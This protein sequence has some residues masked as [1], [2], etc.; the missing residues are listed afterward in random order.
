[1]TRILRPYQIDTIDKLRAQLRKGIKRIVVS[2]CCG[3]GKTTVA[4]EIIDCALEKGKS[5]IFIVDRI[6]LINQ[7]SERLD[8]ENIRHGIIQGNH[9]RSDPNAL[10]QVAS[11]QTL[12]MRRVPH[13]DLGIIDECH[14]LHKT[15]KT[16]MERYYNVT[17]IGL[18]A[19]PFTKGLGK[20]FE[21]L[22]TGA[23]INELISLKYLIEPTV[24]APSEPDMSGV[25]TVAGDYE[26][27]GASC[28]VN[29]PHLVADIVSTWL[30][31][32]KGLPTLV[33]AQDIAHSKAICSDFKDSG[34]NAVHIDCY[35]KTEEKAEIIKQHKSGKI[36]VLVNVGILDKGY[37]YPGLKCGVLARP[38]RSLIL[39]IQQL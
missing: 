6:S 36:T 39:H 30:K 25:K 37:D 23:T 38:T 7:V 33:F 21:S 15:H 20:H 22:V 1:M 16:I 35:L 5:S 14:V 28:A 27:K 17:F 9:P 31:L 32:A 18:S 34:V 26:K 19:T 29:K 12:A 24:Y 10:V 8:E 2:A 4:S 13:F 3:Y 11:I